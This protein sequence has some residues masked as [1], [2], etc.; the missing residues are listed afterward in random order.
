MVG[1]KKLKNM[2]IF[3][4]LRPKPAAVPSTV[5]DPPLV[6]H[7]LSRIEQPL[8][9]PASSAPIDP[10][11]H[12]S[13]DIQLPATHIIERL[14]TVIA[15]LPHT[16]PEGNDGDALAAFAGDP[17]ILADPAMGPDELWED[18]LNGMLK[19]QLGW[20]AVTDT[21]NLVR[22]GKKGLGGLLDFV[23][24]YILERNVSASLF[25]GKLTSLM[26]ALDRMSV[27]P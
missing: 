12:A 24:Y 11:H 22:R 9:Q 18:L 10:V 25:E 16:I 6:Q 21:T 23:K 7:P 1:K 26:E 19:R 3:G 14:R 15:R 13:H 2:S 27:V 8:P 5:A 17:S 4:F 20:G